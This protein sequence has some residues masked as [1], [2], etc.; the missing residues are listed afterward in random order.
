MPLRPEL[1]A[2]VQ[3]QFNIDR[4]ESGLEVP[5]DALDYRGVSLQSRFSVAHEFKTMKA[6]VDAMPED[7]RLRL[8]SIW[9][10]SKACACYH[11]VVTLGMHRSALAEQIRQCLLAATS[12]FNG[13]YIEHG[14]H[15]TQ[16][17]P[18]W[19]EDEAYCAELDEEQ[20]SSLN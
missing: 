3:R 8:A 20:Q 5:Y 11:V 15:V 1:A 16:F 13:L 6:V 7:V 17:D 9:C 10:D 19:P 18:E 4:E 2:A 12:G 14:S